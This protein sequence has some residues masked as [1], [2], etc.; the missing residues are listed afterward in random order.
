MQ[1]AEI[2][3]LRQPSRGLMYVGDIAG[4]HLA[5]KLS[6]NPMTYK[7]KAIWWDHQYP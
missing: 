7:Q 3:L 5:K 2:E 4:C 1:Q 6:K